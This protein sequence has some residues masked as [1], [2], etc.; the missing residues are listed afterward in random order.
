MPIG[1]ED[2]HAGWSSWYF[3]TRGE[4]EYCGWLAYVLDYP[5]LAAASAGVYLLCIGPQFPL[6]WIYSPHN[7]FYDDALSQF[8]K[9]FRWEGKRIN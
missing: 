8:F 7:L 4:Q 9:D 6:E 1:V 5:V 2:Y 3:R